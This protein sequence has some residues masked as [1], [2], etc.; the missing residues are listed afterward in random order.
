MFVPAFMSDIELDREQPR[1][2]DLTRRLAAFARPIQPDR[3]GSGEI[4]ELPTG[5]RPPAP[6]DRVLTT[7]MFTDI[8]GSTESASRLGDAAWRALLER[9][10]RLVREEVSRQGGRFVKSLGDG[11]LAMFDGPSRAMACALAIREALTSLGL[12]VRAGL[13]TGECELLAGGDLGGVAVHIAARIAALAGADEVLASGT[14][15]D[16]SVGSPFTLESRGEQRLRGIADP[17]RL[18]AVAAK[19]P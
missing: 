2:G 4:E 7:V 16:L 15:R 1:R 3:R 6:S 11:G 9:H 12:A 10:D 8:V 14:V 19:G 17:W 13:H 5:T 18:Y